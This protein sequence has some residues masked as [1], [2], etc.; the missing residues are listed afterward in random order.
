MLN[1]WNEEEVGLWRGEV[2]R[3]AQG[4]LA[5]TIGVV[6]GS[7]RL[8]SLGHELWHHDTDFVPFVA[9]ASETDHL[10]VG[11]A[12]RQWAGDALNQKNAEIET[13]EKRHRAAA[14][15]GLRATDQAIWARRITTD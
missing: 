2:V 9:I 13:A 3:V 10:P 7:R 12:R 15:R 6:E 8:A 4:V 1:R 5:G 14:A 11:E